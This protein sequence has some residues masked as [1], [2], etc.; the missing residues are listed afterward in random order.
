[1]G[2]PPPGSRCWQAVSA[3]WNAGDCWL[4]AKLDLNSWGEVGSGKLGTPCERTQPAKLTASCRAWA[5]VRWP[6][7]LD[8]LDE[9]GE[10]EPQAAIIAAA[11]IAAAATGRVEV[12][13][14]M[15]QVVSGRGSHECNTPALTGRSRCVMAL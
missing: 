10:F 12:V 15:T 1:M 5:Y 2:G 7:E 9:L 13:L 11:A 14:N 4:P 3:D 6:P 8:E